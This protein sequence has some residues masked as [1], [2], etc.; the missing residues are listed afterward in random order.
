MASE[1]EIPI[2]FAEENEETE[3]LLENLNRGLEGNVGEGKK[4][5]AAQSM[6]CY[7]YNAGYCFRHLSNYV[8]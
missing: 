6:L 1:I 8:V 5:S 3:E 7:K 2:Y 4:T